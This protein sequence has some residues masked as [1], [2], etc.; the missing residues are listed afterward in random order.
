MTPIMKKI[1]LTLCFL[2]SITILIKA[3]RN[4]IYSDNIK[5]LQVVSNDDWLSPPIMVLGGSN[6]MNIDFDDLSHTY[7]RYTYTVEHCEADWTPSTDIFESDYMEGFNGNPI[8][9]FEK[10]INT[11]VLYTHYSL[12]IPNKNCQLKMSGNYRLTVYDDD[13]NSEKVLTAY[14][15]VVQPV[16]G[17]SMDITTNTDIDVNASHQQVG[18]ELSYGSLN[19]TD[20]AG[21]IKT[22]VM[23]NGR[24]DN[25]V[26]DVKPNYIMNNKLIWT[27]NRS[28]IFEAGNEYHK[29]EMLDVHHPTL[30]I[31]HIDFIADYYHC[32]LFANEPRRNYIYEPD[33][34]GSFYIRNSDNVDNNTYSDYLWVH[35]TMRC[36]R[37]NGNVYVNGT[38]TNDSFLPEYL[39][40]YDEINKC[41]EAT[42]LQKQG[43]YSYQYLVQND[44]GTSSFLPEEGSYYQTENKYQALVYFKGSG[45]RTYRLLGYGNVTLK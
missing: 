44:N 12:T 10:S 22:V 45:E 37:L 40:T 20:P 17:V 42:I 1:I 18:M 26:F 5:S 28:L 23:Q 27:H 43:Y 14:F 33:A 21:Q 29:F 6:T 36:D 16:L 7:H 25:A 31:E 4:E 8:D 2:L 19:V 30:G 3:Q 34:N 9:N 13:N 35:Y 41:Y 38:W 39:M 15:M 32:T 11:T 24:W